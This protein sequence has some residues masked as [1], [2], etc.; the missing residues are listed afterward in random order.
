M[1]ISALPIELLQ[2]IF[3]TVRDDLLAAD[4]EDMSWMSLARVSRHWR[5]VLRGDPFLWTRLAFTDKTPFYVVEAALDRSQQVGGVDLKF[6]ASSS[7]PPSACGWLMHLSMGW[8][9]STY[10]L[11][12][13]VRFLSF[14]WREGVRNTVFEGLEGLRA[15]GV[16]SLV[17]EEHEDPE[18]FD[19]DDD[20]ALLESSSDCGSIVSGD[21]TEADSESETE[22]ADDEDNSDGDHGEGASND[23]TDADTDSGTD[24]DSGLDGHWDGPVLDDAS[25]EDESSDVSISDS[26]FSLGDDSSTY[27][28]SESDRG[29]YLSELEDEEGGPATG[30][31]SGDD[32]DADHEDFNEDTSEEETSSQASDPAEGEND[33]N[34]V[35]PVQVESPR[36]L[37]L[38]EFPSLINLAASSVLVSIPLQ[39]KGQLTD[40]TLMHSSSLGHEY[41]GVEFRQS[42]ML[43]VLDGCVQL[44]SLRLCNTLIVTG[45]DPEE[46]TVFLPSL[47]HLRVEDVLG[48]VQDILRFFMPFP[49]ELTRMDL[50]SLLCTEHWT[51][52]LEGAFA[53]NLPE[54]FT[55]PHFADT[56]AL[57]LQVDDEFVLRGQTST[58]LQWDLR[59]MRDPEDWSENATELLLQHAVLDLWDPRIVAATSISTLAIHIAP[60]YVTRE[61]N[62]AGLISGLPCVSKFEL[63]GDEAVAT[64]IEAT[65]PG[66]GVTYW[67][68]LTEFCFCLAIFRWDLETHMQYLCEQL[69][70]SDGSPEH[71]L[72]VKVYLRLPGV[73]SPLEPGVA[74]PHWFGS[75]Y[76]YSAMNALSRD[77]DGRI[78]LL[79]HRCKTCHQPAEWVDVTYANPEM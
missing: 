19:G 38:P 30:T 59:A 41:K 33:G 45:D 4:E 16:V 47:K 43:D 65:R 17:L 51:P 46:R 14:L 7:D 22:N 3:R 54:D 13:T 62:W 74:R 31:E 39:V 72:G 20:G 48:G 56:V 32:H 9:L 49:E 25:Y 67:P 24:T 71:G 34:A 1:S 79:G 68:A 8:P 11:P 78:Q 6:T 77:Y 26:T 75:D 29:K 52:V 57:N 10:T 55:V 28:D 2:I 73:Y 70:P 5:D 64:F 40:M 50:R 63:G 53:G 69:W 27:L 18:D 21:D 42:W 15:D 44:G 36:I 61:V 12:G 60:Q 58:L 35:E 76:I 23:D 37:Q 66:R